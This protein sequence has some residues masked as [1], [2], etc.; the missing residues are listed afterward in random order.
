MSEARPFLR[1]GVRRDQMDLT[2]QFVGFLRDVR[3]SGPRRRKQKT[4]PQHQ[5]NQQACWTT[6]NHNSVFSQSQKVAARSL[7]A[8]ALVMGSISGA[9]EQ[10]WKH[11]HPSKPVKARSRERLRPKPAQL[12]LVLA[13]GRHLVRSAGSCRTE[14]HFSP[15]P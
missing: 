14:K 15:P 9:Q 1:G 2:R 6:L 12:F 11:D 13:P 4:E 8:A 5:D 10:E 3:R 7:A